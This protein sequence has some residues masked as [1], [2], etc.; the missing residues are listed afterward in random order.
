MPR[1][2]GVPSYRLHRQSGQAIVTLA[3]SAGRRKDVLLG[4]HGTAESKAEYGRV[5]AAWNAQKGHL[6]GPASLTVN[7]LILAFWEH[8]EK[9]Y[10]RPDNTTTRPQMS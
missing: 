3:D 9:Y 4:K 10:R 7:G 5:L 6:P 2:K 8:A 1:P